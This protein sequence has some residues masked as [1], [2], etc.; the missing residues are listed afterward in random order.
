MNID[1]AKICSM[2][3]NQLSDYIRRCE[4]NFDNGLDSIADE[5]AERRGVRLCGL[6]G[7][8]CAGKTTG[9]FKLTRNLAKYGISV[10]TISIDDFFHNN[11][12][13]PLDEDGKA[14]F[15][16][17]SYVHTDLLHTTLEQ[18]LNGNT[19]MLPK[20]DFPNGRRIDNYEKYTPKKNEIIILEGLHALNDV[21][22]SG[23]SRDEYYRIFIN[24]CGTLCLDGK[25]MFDGR[26]LRL[27]RR[28]IRDYKFRAADAQLTFTLWENVVKGEI[29]N[30]H[31]FEDKADFKLDSMFEYEPCVVKR[32]VEEVLRGL[33]RDSIYVR[34]AERIWRKLEKVPDI[35]ER[36]VPMDSLMQEFLGGDHFKY[37]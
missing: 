5:I 12:D 8:S 7:P 14:D 3:E 29:K 27:C 21:M 15:E 31:P 16:S 22:Y 26:E 6:A 28:L 9:S 19:V 23:I 11:S 36:L 18:I 2:T 35:N 33:K 37:D 32:Q 34:E 1:S 25:P 10:R 17:L 24:V 13:G 30:I 20:Y 4:K